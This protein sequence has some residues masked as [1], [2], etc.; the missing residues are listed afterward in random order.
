M[1]GSQFQFEQALIIKRYTTLALD[2]NASTPSSD[3]KQTSFFIE[4][5]TFFFPI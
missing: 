3:K 5:L 4:L 1:Y 2:H